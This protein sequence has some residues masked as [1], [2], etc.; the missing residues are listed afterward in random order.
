LILDDSVAKS[1]S[2][3]RAQHR[4]PAPPWRTLNPVKALRISYLIG[5][6]AAARQIEQAESRNGT[7]VC[8][9]ATWGI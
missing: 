4:P 7:S 6:P 9:L 1:S 3:A 2:K 5:M 8:K